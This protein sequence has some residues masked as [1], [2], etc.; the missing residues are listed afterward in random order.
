MSSPRN[1]VWCMGWQAPGDYTPIYDIAGSDFTHVIVASFHINN[2]AAGCYF[3][4]TSGWTTI[5]RTLDYPPYL[6]A[7]NA[8]SFPEGLA[9]ASAPYFA[10]QGITLSSDLSVATGSAANTWT[11]TDNG[12]GGVTY[13]MQVDTTWL[14]FNGSPIYSAEAYEQYLPALNAGTFPAS[15]RQASAA[16]FGQAGMYLSATVN[17]TPGSDGTSW[18]LT[19]LAN[20]YTYLIWIKP[21]AGLT[22]SNSFDVFSAKLAQFWQAVAAL[23]AAGK[24]LLVSIGGGSNEADW[25]NMGTNVLQAMVQFA[26]LLATYS[27]DGI[28]LDWEGGG[29]LGTLETFITSYQIAFP[30]TTFTMSPYQSTIGALAKVWAEVNSVAGGNAI[31]WINAQMYEG[32]SNHD[33]PYFAKFLDPVEKRLGLSSA[34]AAELIVPGWNAGSWDLTRITEQLAGVVKANPTVGGGFTFTL[35]DIAAEVDAWAT[36]ISA[37]LS[38]PD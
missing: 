17:V 26:D 23:D 13:G 15:L 31:S 16:G 11:L 25:V 35:A 14:S 28:D 10:A 20:D 38:Q 6:A 1:V 32:S 18:V 22:I 30:A 24:I 34:A 9:V 2:Q 36:A 27:L 12:N 7:L 33:A 8:G 4:I 5:F 21:G 3:R 37:A 29:S 19:D